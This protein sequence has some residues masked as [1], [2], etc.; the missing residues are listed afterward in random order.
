MWYRSW[1]QVMG[2]LPPIGLACQPPDIGIAQASERQ[3]DE[4]DTTFHS[5][6]QH[7]IYHV[8]KL[9]DGRSD[10]KPGGLSSYGFSPMQTNG[11]K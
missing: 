5:R 6:R 9:Y 2:P 8:S 3:R 1:G 10:L 11:S 7:G 4:H